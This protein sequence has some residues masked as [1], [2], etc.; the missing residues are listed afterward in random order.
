MNTLAC[1]LVGAALAVP[2]GDEKKTPKDTDK[3]QGVW[4]V[5]AASRGGVPLNVKVDLPTFT[6]AIVGDRYVFMAHGGT[7][8]LDPE[9]GHFD[10]QVTAGR[11]SG[12]SLP[13]RYELKD[14][15]LTLT[16]PSSLLNP[17]RPDPKQGDGPVGVTYTLKRDAK[18]TKDEAEKVLKDHT[19]ALPDKLPAGFGGKAGGKGGG[20]FANPGGG[21]APAAPPAG[22]ATEK[23][24][25]RILERLERIEQRLDALEKR[26]PAPQ[27]KK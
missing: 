9:K 8:T 19:A 5:T 13:C 26:L 20:G 12:K 14:D 17:M 2:A 23:L 27:E 22:A 6:F 10:L 4:Q 16:L 3:L 24:L 21:F 18:A 15:T 1:L 7:F 25:E 11:Y